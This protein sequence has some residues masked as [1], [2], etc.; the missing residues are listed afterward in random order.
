M[1]SG[2]EITGVA[3]GAFP[4]F[5]HFVQGYRSGC[6]SMKAW[7]KFKSIFKRLQHAIDMEKYSYISNIRLLCL[8]A[9]LEDVNTIIR[10]FEQNSP[11]PNIAKVDFDKYT[12]VV[13]RGSYHSYFETVSLI[14]DTV[15]EFRMVLGLDE[16]RQAELLRELDCSQTSVK[17]MQRM[18]SYWDR[19]TTLWARPELYE[20]INQIHG[21]NE[22]LEKLLRDATHEQQLD[23]RHKGNVHG[24]RIIHLR[25]GSQSLH[26]YVS[27]GCLSC[28]CCFEGPVTKH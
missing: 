26:R 20:L 9:G 22:Y 25:R 8:E 6:K 17:V 13:L 16:E 10:S 27:A 2:F 18:W 7:L 11:L 21:Y 12:R 15:E 23:Q 14:K 4:V 1:A 5:V 19:L 24:E 28:F 3:L